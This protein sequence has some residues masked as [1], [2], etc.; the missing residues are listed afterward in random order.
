MKQKK[1]LSDSKS[2]LFCTVCTLFGF[3]A[4]SCSE[5]NAEDTLPSPEENAV[6]AT[7][8]ACV[9]GDVEA[10]RALAKANPEAHLFEGNE[11]GKWDKINLKWVKT[12]DGKYAVSAL[13]VKKDAG[14]AHLVLN[15]DGS[16]KGNIQF[17]Q[18]QSVDVESATLQEVTVL[19]QPALQTVRIN[20]AGEA[21]AESINVQGDETLKEIAIEGMPQVTSILLGGDDLEKVTLTDLPQLQEQSNLK[22]RNGYDAEGNEVEST[23]VKELTLK[24]DMKRLNGLYLTGLGLEKFNLE[25]SLPEL[26]SLT[27]NNNKLSGKFEVNGMEKIQ[28]LYL[29]HNDLSSV[30]VS[31]C[32]A[33]KEF[34]ASANEEL[35]ECSLSLP[36][37]KILDLNK[38]GISTLDLSSF[39]NLTKVSAYDGKLTSVTLSGQ[40]TKLADVN[41]SGNDLSGID[42]PQEASAIYLL[43][44]NDNDI[45]TLDVSHLSLL[46]RVSAN[47]NKLETLKV[48]QEAES[49]ELLECLNNHLTAKSLREIKN[50]LTE[51]SKWD[52]APQSVLGRV[53]VQQKQIDASEEV[54]G[55]KLTPL[56][57][58]FDGKQ[59]GDAP[60]A[61][62]AEQGGIYTFK[63]QGKY[64]VICTDLGFEDWLF[65]VF[66][67]FDPY[68]I[69]EIEL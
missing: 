18:L 25:T 44:L 68:L 8:A 54:N 27:L 31:G 16:K 20:G 34:D 53:D 2:L 14:I 55:L 58:K 26:R 39:A 21:L 19:N 5:D 50:T 43:T 24:G 3:L 59:W 1:K 32:P 11:P 36:A 10:L 30:S 22:F 41:L 33:L 57:Q 13:Q 65:D 48:P 64:R 46:E 52:V 15:L 4:V 28:I 67:R 66:S 69:G 47:N 56:V 51:L 37:L 40:N 35:S 29:S 60:A 12:A 45:Q 63:G 61:E 17:S 9:P 49:F 42:F 62:F 38:T 6:P 7:V 23:A